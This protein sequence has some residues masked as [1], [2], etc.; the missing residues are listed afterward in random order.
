[1]PTDDLPDMKYYIN[2]VPLNTEYNEL[3][4]MSVYYKNRKWVAYCDKND[5]AISKKRKLA[6]KKIYKPNVVYA[7]IDE[8]QTAKV[9]C[10]C[11][12]PPIV[13]SL[14]FKAILE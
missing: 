13:E 6:I 10:V 8:T 9:D 2:G 1:M 12:I 3:R 14:K 7:I 4:F 5:F 11:K